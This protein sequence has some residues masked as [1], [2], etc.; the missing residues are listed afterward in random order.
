MSNDRAETSLSQDDDSRTTATEPSSTEGK[1]WW[2]RLTKEM[3]SQ[4]V[5]FFAAILF[6]CLLIFTAG[7]LHGLL[8]W[9]VG[10]ELLLLGG[11]L[12]LGVVILKKPESPAAAWRTTRE[13]FREAA[14]ADTAT[15]STSHTPVDAPAAPGDHYG[16]LPVAFCCTVLALVLAVLAVMAI[17]DLSFEQIGPWLLALGAIVFAVLS[18]IALSYAPPGPNWVQRIAGI[19]GRLLLAVVGLAV[20]A[21]ATLRYFDYGDTGAPPS[22]WWL[23]LVALGLLI[24]L[25]GAGPGRRR[26]SPGTAAHA[27]EHARRAFEQ[28]A[29]AEAYH[30]KTELITSATGTDHDPDA[31]AAVAE[32]AASHARAFAQNAKREATNALEL[33]EGVGTKVGAAKRDAEAAAKSAY[34]ARLAH[35]RAEED[36]RTSKA[37]QASD[38]GAPS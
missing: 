37:D 36:Q 28:A 19:D 29:Q 12:Y 4:P 20:V 30:Q 26:K 27:V 21:L 38:P 9:R 17:W 14:R 24:T 25:A 16:Y 15:S 3:L 6:G 35:D 8:S 11:A 33:E 2:S 1:R 22:Q 5:V 7:L 10:I 32:R 31:P 18:L 13:R 34:A 23:A